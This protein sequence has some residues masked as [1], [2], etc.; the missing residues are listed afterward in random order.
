MGWWGPED[1]SLAGQ[2]R[3]LVP[4]SRLKTE[5]KTKQKFIM[6]WKTQLHKS[7]RLDSEYRNVIFLLLKLFSYLDACL[8]LL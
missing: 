4:S 1:G 2:V 8:D 7:S 6:H 3:L 5:D